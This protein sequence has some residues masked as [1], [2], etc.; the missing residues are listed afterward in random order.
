MLLAPSAIEEVVRNIEGLGDEY[1]V[2]VEKVGDADQIKLRVEVLPEAEAQCT[3]IESELVDQLRLKTNLRY[4]I[5]ICGCDT[6]PRYEVKARRFQR[7]T[8]KRVKTLVFCPMAAV[9]FVMPASRR[10]APLFQQNF[11]DSRLRGNDPR[12]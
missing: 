6:L 11:L 5:E 7:F 3:L 12:N 8:Q 10:V 4:D 2:I 1:E 9:A